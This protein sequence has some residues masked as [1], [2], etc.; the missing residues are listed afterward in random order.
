MQSSTKTVLAAVCLGA[1]ATAPPPEPTGGPR[2]LRA[3]EHLEVAREHEESARQNLVWPAIAVS[4]DNPNVPWLRAWDAT[5]EDE[6][7]AQVH[8][9]E[10]A[11]IQA[12]YEQACGSRSHDE[13]AISPLHRYAVGGWPTQTGVILYLAP[14]AGPPDRLLADIACHRAWMMLAPTGMDDCPLDLPGIVVDARGDEHGITLSIVVRDSK[15]VDELHR[16][17]ARELESSEQLHR[18]E[19][20]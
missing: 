17:A 5:S 18:G 11:A 19:S 10:A 7:I 1:C 8:R 15:L 16:R 6:R 14:D 3:S 4:P 9:S 13:S 12:A 20:P 2:G